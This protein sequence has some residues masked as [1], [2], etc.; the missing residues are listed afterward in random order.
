MCH[1]HI[2]LSLRDTFQKRKGVNFF[3]TCTEKVVENHKK[4]LFLKITD[5]L[6]L[7]LLIYLWYTVKTTLNL[8]FTNSLSIQNWIYCNCKYE[9]IV[10]V[11]L[12]SLFRGND[13]SPWNKWST[14]WGDKNTGNGKLQVSYIWLYCFLNKELHLYTSSKH[15]W[16]IPEGQY[17]E[18]AP[19]F[20][21]THSINEIPVGVIC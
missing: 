7:C 8:C 6:V 4:I 14:L 1:C 10:L 9:K 19:K 3:S 17:Q 15:C 18:T 11:F 5:V 13:F 2:H 21:V 20:C 16:K 12:N